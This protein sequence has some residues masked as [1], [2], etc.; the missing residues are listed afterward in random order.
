[1]AQVWTLKAEDVRFS[2]IIHVNEV[3]H[4]AT[5]WRSMLISVQMYGLTHASCLDE[6]WNEVRLRGVILP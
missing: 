2:E 4:A 5:I 3:P 6:T 1:M